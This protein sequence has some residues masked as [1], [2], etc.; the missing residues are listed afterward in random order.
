MGDGY[1]RQPVTAVVV[2]L[3]IVSALVLLQQNADR[4]ISARQE[5]LSV[6]AENLD[7]PWGIEFMPSGDMLVTERPGTLL[8][9]ERESGRFTARYEIRGVEHRG[10]GG[11]LGVELHPE[12]RQNRWLYLYMTT[13]K[14]DMLRN[15][16]VRY[17]LKG[18]EL[19]NSTVIIDGLPGALYHDGGRLEFGP[20]GKLYV[21]AGDATHEYWAQQKDILAGKI[22]RL[23]PDG[24]IPEGNPFD[25]PVYSYGHRNPQGLAWV[26]GTLWATEHGDTRHD[27]LNRIVKGGNYGWPVIE[28][29]MSRE[30]MREPEIYAEGTTWA[31]A[32]AAYYQGSVFF[33]GLR[34]STLYE[35]EL[36]NGSVKKLERHLGDRFGRLRAV[37][38]GP[39][40]YMYVSTSNTDG[41][42]SPAEND[43]RIVRVDPDRWT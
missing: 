6:V 32:D 15:R 23:N 11:L 25:S 28:A 35:A 10:E 34:G 17:T 39:E 21:T 2:I 27:E 3:V 16:V 5:N 40:G 22:L 31:P 19:H 41:R 26:N 36:E 29:D 37:E 43:D 18:S 24:S 4:R 14:G 42:G 30:G 7:V 13:R 38:I 1:G 8:R 12:F 33:A 9:I 20:D